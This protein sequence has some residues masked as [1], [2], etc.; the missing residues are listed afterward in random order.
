MQ[1]KEIF[2]GVDVSKETLDVAVYGTR[3]HLRIVNNSEGFKQLLSW[4]KS[5]SVALVDCWVV[6][7]YTGGYEYRLIQFCQSRQIRFSRVPGLEIKKSLGMQR[8]KNDKI[9]ARRISEYGH[10][11]S[12][13]LKVSTVCNAAITR[14]KQFLTQRS[15][16]INDRKAHEHRLNELLAMMDF[17]AT[18]PLLKHYKQGVDFANKM[19]DK[20]EKE[21]GKIIKQEPSMN[22]TF[23]L[24]T[25]IPGIGRVNGWMTI[26]FTENFSCF[27]DGRKYGAYCG[28]VPYEHQS[29]KSIRGKSR[30]SHMA[31]KQVKA[32]LT[33]AAKASVTHDPEMKAYYERR[34]AM[35]K[36][37][38][39]IMNEVK[40]KLIL[41]MF[42]VVNKGVSY[43]KN[44]TKQENFLA[45]I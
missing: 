6:M 35:G 45:G 15:G 32:D 10:E 44:L 9:D 38:M 28:V 29:G 34:D 13:K 24:I 11:K 14:L 43:V 30:I 27:A 37:H 31:N 23:Q 19:I 41:R 40:F 26:A 20:A 22:K 25:S 5:L 42:A 12:A 36:H 7:E 33:M 16:F 3:N 17:K 2:I 4:L 18:D 21:I 8:G 1:K 39:G